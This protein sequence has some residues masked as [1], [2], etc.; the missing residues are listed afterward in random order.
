MSLLANLRWFLDHQDVGAPTRLHRRGV[1]ADPRDGAGSVL[2]APALDS[3]F[4]RWLEA[5]EWA[6]T[7]EAIEVTCYHV[8]RAEGTLCGVC[9]VRDEEGIPVIETSLRQSERELYRWP[10]RA[11]IARLH[12]AVVRPGRPRLSSTLLAIAHSGGDLAA[13]QATLSRRCPALGN[14]AVAMA[15]FAFALGRI[16]STWREDAPPRLLPRE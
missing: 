3:A 16:R 10:M 6:R 12:R 8:G 9:S 1:W 11:A 14:E 15:H 4:T 7:V 2:G 5:G 13:A